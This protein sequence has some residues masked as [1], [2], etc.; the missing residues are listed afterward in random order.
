ML[1]AVKSNEFE[2][3]LAE[4]LNGS[5]TLRSCIEPIGVGEKSAFYVRVGQAIEDH[6]K[7]LSYCGQL[8]LCRSS[9]HQCGGD[10]GIFEALAEASVDAF[11]KML[12]GHWGHEMSDPAK[13]AQDAS[14]LCF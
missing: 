1:Q 4:D 11:I 10:A 6:V 3:I 5:V 13:V 12:A 2:R 9:R 14:P 7:Y 8:S